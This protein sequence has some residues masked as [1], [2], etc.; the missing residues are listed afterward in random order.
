M[1][2]KLLMTVFLVAVGSSALAQNIV[3]YPLEKPAGCSA[4]A[5]V[6]GVRAAPTGSFI[7]VGKCVGGFAEGEGEMQSFR[8]GE[9][10]ERNIGARHDGLEEGP[11][12]SINTNPKSRENGFQTYFTLQHGLPIGPITLLSP[13]GI[14]YGEGI[15]DG[16]GGF[17]QTSNAASP[18]LALFG[19]MLEGDKRVS[20][21]KL[22]MQM[23]GA[24]VGGSTTSCFVL[25]K[26]LKYTDQATTFWCNALP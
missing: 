25:M 11:N 3:T 14:V 16:L 18:L 8:E 9:M 2:C 10:V 24:K 13:D 5:A 17:K 4:R 15:G 12:I 26:A 22:F 6:A 19:R 21:N 20:G 7:W 1:V 23:F